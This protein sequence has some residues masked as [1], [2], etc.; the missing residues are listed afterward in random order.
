VDSNGH[1]IVT[2]DHVTLK[3]QVMTTIRLRVPILRK[4]L[5]MLTTVA[6]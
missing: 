5:E 6:N 4:Q 1:V 3:G 2:D